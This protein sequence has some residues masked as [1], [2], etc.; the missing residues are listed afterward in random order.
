MGQTATSEKLATETPTDTPS[1]REANTPEVQAAPILPLAE[2]KAEAK[3]LLPQAQADES[4]VVATLR[5]AIAGLESAHPDIAA[6]CK[7][8]DD[9]R[10]L[11]VA[12]KHQQ[13]ADKQIYAFKHLFNLDDEADSPT[14]SENSAKND[15]RVVLDSLKA[16]FGSSNPFD[17]KPSSSPFGSMA[18]MLRGSRFVPASETHNW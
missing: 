1:M 15:G 8:V 2:A 12:L 14:K 5:V 4:V 6:M 16:I 10:S 17:D 7:T 9:Y 3:T 11:K 18:S 13:Q